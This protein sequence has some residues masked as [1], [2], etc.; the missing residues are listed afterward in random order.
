MNAL[1]PVSLALVLVVPA[2]ARPP[3]RRPVAD[4]RTFRRLVRIVSPVFSPGGRRI[5]FVTVRTDDLHNRDDRT[6][7]VV[8]TAGGRPRALVRGLKGLAAPRWAP[9]GRT[10]SFLAS[11][12]GAKPEIYAVGARGGTPRRLS[13]APEGVEQYAW[14][15]GGHRLA[16]VA[17]DP[18]RFSARD[19]WSGHD[20]FAVHDD[21]DL[22]TAP[23][24]P[25]EIWVLRL[26][27]F[28][29]SRITHGPT[30]VLEGAPPFNGSVSAP[31][32]SPDGRWIVYTRQK[33]ADDSD[34]DATTIVAVPASGGVPRVL[35]RH[36]T[37]EYDPFFAPRGDLV[38][39]LTPHG[40]GPVSDMD[41]F[42]TSLRGGRSR[43]V[44]ADLDRNVATTY[45]WMPGGKAV[46]GLADDGVRS[47]LYLQPL[48]GR[49]R[50]IPTG[51]LHPLDLAVSARG[52]VAY[53]AD[54][55]ARPPEL[56]VLARPGARPR[57]L[58]RF[59]RDLRRYAWPRS[60]ALRWRAPDGM[61]NDGILTYPLD[62]RPGHRY[63][64]VVFS[65]GGPEAAST[66]DFDAG[67][68]GPLRDLFAA[69]GDVVFE[70]NYRGSDNLGNAH[71]HAIYRDPGAGPD[72]DILAGIRLLEKRGLVDPRR[73]AAV[74]HSYGGYLTAWLIGH[75]H[76]W[77]CA[78][79]ADGV[80]DWT[81]E[82]ELSGSGN[83]AWTRD[84][85]G[86]SPWNPRSR[87]LYVTG[88]PITDAG[89]ITTPTLILSGTADVTVPI[90]ESFA[91]Y[92]ALAARGVPVRF[93]AIPGAAHMPQDPVQLELFYRAIERWV[94]RC[95]GGR[96]RPPSRPPSAIPAGPRA[97]GQKSVH[98]A[99]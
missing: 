20:L 43:D 57:R 92:H 15:P 82:Y 76:F 6:L 16:Y 29:V 52:A 30:S 46:V 11:V 66:E 38:A 96:V 32:W 27:S 55:A 49:G 97:R 63:P 13:R 54:G 42:V 31:S 70:P 79:V 34:T 24:E 80:T 73:I 48:R 56:Y 75:Q 61:R 2:V 12:H 84:S 8:P 3:A 77:R 40:P 74:G 85:L 90:A 53:V 7:W 1:V 72:S 26:P 98:R 9:G 83:M 99:V 25:S 50:P 89:R 91:L 71:L 59:N 64:L 88:S 81:E 94:D 5:L 87:R 37:Y 95:L 58:T 78:V 86:G 14:S 17:P 21:D 19:R 62:Y 68:I 28:A 22:I 47:R 18:P 39:Y 23:P 33:D 51:G 45:A 93:L 44:S 4:L 60:V 69:H 65:H 35:T 67:E 10:V 41:V 36:A